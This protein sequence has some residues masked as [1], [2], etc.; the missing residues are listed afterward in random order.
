MLSS[1]YD[2]EIRELQSRAPVFWQNRQT[3]PG[4]KFKYWSASVDSKS[5]PWG[6]GVWTRN[7]NKPLQG[8]FKPL[9]GLQT[10]WLKFNLKM[11]E[12]LIIYASSS[13]GFMPKTTHIHPNLILASNALKYTYL[14][15][16]DKQFLLC[17]GR[18]LG[19]VLLDLQPGAGTYSSSESAS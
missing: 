14:K 10:R 16:S 4:I 17:P 8:V 5:A 11:T 9:P 3:P 2:F 1:L 7:S 12:S 15:A 6:Q 18:K 19:W 13:L